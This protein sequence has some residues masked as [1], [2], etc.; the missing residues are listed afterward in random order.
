ML[1]QS[2]GPKQRD[3]SEAKPPD[4]PSFSTARIEAR[5][6]SDVGSKAKSPAKSVTLEPSSFVMAELDLWTENLARTLDPN[7]VNPGDNA[8]NPIDLDVIKSEDLEEILVSAPSS[9]VPSSATPTMSN[10]V[11][12]RGT[13]P[14][15]HQDLHDGH[16][17][18][19]AHYFLASD[20]ALQVS[21]AKRRLS[22]DQSS[23]KSKQ[24]CSDRIYVRVLVEPT[25]TSS[26]RHKRG[27]DSSK[28][29]IVE[30]DISAPRSDLFERLL[31]CQHVQ[32]PR[33][34]STQSAFSQPCATGRQGA[35]EICQQG[36]SNGHI[37]RETATESD[38]TQ[39]S[40]METCVHRACNPIIDPYVGHR[41]VLD[42][43]NK[44]I[45]SFD[46]VQ[47]RFAGFQS[48]EEEYTAGITRVTE[49]LKT[50]RQ[51]LESES[52]R[53]SSMSIK[54]MEV[55]RSIDVN[56]RYLDLCTSSMTGQDTVEGERILPT[57]TKCA[58]TEVA[59]KGAWA[60]EHRERTAAKGIMEVD[61]MLL[62]SELI[63]EGVNREIFTLDRRNIER[64]L[65]LAS[66]EW[67]DLSNQLVQRGFLMFW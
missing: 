60:K 4:G 61:I 5:A 3:D 41:D 37:P 7:A 56:L 46:D 67:V 58:T 6:D 43:V 28:E 62:E 47:K 27:G 52:E 34:A 8:D 50:K 1:S 30:L 33:D 31:R 15:P 66:A 20:K 23:H 14:K 19:A 35:C 32:H 55:S 53:I 54:R 22:D 2:S 16:S 9:P 21:G 64:D 12:D 63:T 40:S 24:L 48:R 25:P 39:I 65:A 36:S 44:F 17:D 49:Q 57:I 59:Q 51:A 10:K 26:S 38:Q 18:S 13:L 11:T 29:P 42:R 45:F